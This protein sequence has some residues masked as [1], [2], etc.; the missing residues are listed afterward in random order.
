MVE[1]LP[2]AVDHLRAYIEFDEHL[3]KDSPDQVAAWEK[4]YAEWDVQPKSSPCIFDTT[5]HGA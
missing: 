1:A 5:N 4:E 3:R 2:E